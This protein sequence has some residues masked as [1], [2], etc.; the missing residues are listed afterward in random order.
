LYQIE[1]SCLNVETKMLLV[2][3]PYVLLRWENV[4]HR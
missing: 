4:L 1:S 2:Y 3:T